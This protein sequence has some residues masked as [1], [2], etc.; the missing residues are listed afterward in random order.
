MPDRTP[1]APSRGPV[2]ARR[3]TREAP[4][5]PPPALIAPPITQCPSR[6][7]GRVSPALPLRGGVARPLPRAAPVRA[8]AAGGRPRGRPPR[9]RRKSSLSLRRR[10]RPSARAGAAGGQA[11]A[12]LEASP[13]GPSDGP[14]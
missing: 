10:R 2:G 3:C 4:F 11:V 6:L 1:R 13:M 8:A 5:S 14:L 9:P 12:S 7:L